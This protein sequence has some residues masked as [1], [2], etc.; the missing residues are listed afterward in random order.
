MLRMWRRIGNHWSS[1]SERFEIYVTHNGDFDFWT[2]LGRLR[3]QEDVGMW[4]RNVLHVHHHVAQCDSVKI[5]GVMELL[6]TQVPSPIS[7][8]DRYHAGY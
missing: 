7:F 5:G 2:I 1:A 8:S 6:R 3:T 4:L